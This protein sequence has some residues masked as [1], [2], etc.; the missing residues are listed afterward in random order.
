MIPHFYQCPFYFIDYVIAQTC[1]FQYWIRNEKI[2]GKPGKATSICAK[3]KPALQATDRAGR[4]AV[5][6]RGRLPRVHRG[7]S[8]RLAE[9]RRC[10]KAVA[11]ETNRLIL[12]RPAVTH[13]MN[14]EDKF[15]VCR[16]GL[17]FL[18]QLNDML[19]QG[20]GCSVVIDTP[21]MIE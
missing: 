16:I 1:A 9:R 10:G 11:Q 14:G 17:H 20:T 21:C 12:L 7:Q 2:P 13:P 8:V 4:T 19:I 6:V 18:P 3:R 15:W 5:T